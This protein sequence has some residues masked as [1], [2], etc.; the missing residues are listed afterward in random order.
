MNKQELETKLENM[1]EALNGA[2]GRLTV[3]AMSG[4][5]PEVKEAHELLI[6]FAFDFTNL[7]ND[8]LLTD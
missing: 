5:N 1:E 6:S 4:N 2:I 8:E 7:I 3:T